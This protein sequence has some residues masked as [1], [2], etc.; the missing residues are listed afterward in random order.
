MAVTGQFSVA[1]DTLA[2][3]LFLMWRCV[4]EIDRPEARVIGAQPA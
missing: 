1:A 3:R 4:M 2:S